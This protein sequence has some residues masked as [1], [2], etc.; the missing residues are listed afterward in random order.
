MQYSIINCGLP[1]WLSGKDPPASVGDAGFIPGSER[2]LGERSG[3]PLQYS[4]LG[5][6]MDRGAWWT[7][8]HGVIRVGH[9]LV[10][11]QQQIINCSPHG[12]YTF[13][14]LIYIIIGNLYLWT[15]LIHFP[16]PHPNP[17]PSNHQSVL[18]TYK[19]DFVCFVGFFLFQ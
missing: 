19:L 10:T 3:S 1:W 14:W 4:C 17:H 7:R 6:P 5:N 13:A 18:C 9:Y 8:V 11:T 12:V 2:S 16:T 15:L